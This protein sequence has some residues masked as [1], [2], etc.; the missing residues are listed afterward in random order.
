MH[1]GRDLDLNQQI[2][3]RPCRVYNSDM[4]IHVNAT[5]LYTYPDVS[6]ICGEPNS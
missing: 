3:Q 6:V 1:I 5:G 4:Q 2:R